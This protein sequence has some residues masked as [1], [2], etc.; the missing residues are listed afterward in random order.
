MKILG[1]ILFVSVFILGWTLG[2]VFGNLDAEQPTAI[3]T[4]L[5]GGN[6][7]KVSPSDIVKEEDIR[8]YDDRVII[9]LNDPLWAKF[10]DTNS[11]DPV[12][13]IGANAI[14]IK[15]KTPEQIQQGD[16][17]SFANSHSSG[18]I[19]HRVIEIGNDD[20][21]W[22]AITKGDNNPYKDPDKVRFDDIKKL[23]VAIIY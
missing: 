2:S 12:F 16:I 6:H 8:V 14:Q 19:I 9:Y 11:M 15:P 3:A 1:L 4:T 18:T 21:G 20:L 5:L 10:T 17:I 7:E 23:L 13:D 22:Y